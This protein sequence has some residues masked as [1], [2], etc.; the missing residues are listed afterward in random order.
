MLVPLRESQTG[1]PR[2]P[3]REGEIGSWL[4]CASVSSVQDGVYAL[5]KAHKRCTLSPRSFP[6]VA[7][8]TV[9]VFV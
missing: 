2:S 9:T 3:D 5:G 7:F 6:K 1:A 4:L 8:E